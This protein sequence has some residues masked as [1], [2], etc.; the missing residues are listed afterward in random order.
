MKKK[1][2]LFT[3]QSNIGGY[4]CQESKKGNYNIDRWMEC[5]QKYWKARC[6]LCRVLIAYLIH[7]L[8]CIFI[9]KFGKFSIN[10]IFFSYFF[11]SNNK[12]YLTKYEQILL[13]WI[14]MLCYRLSLGLGQSQWKLCWPNQWCTHEH[15]WG[16]VVLKI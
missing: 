11:I 15:N 5:V 1:I 9:H 6:V 13:F 4:Y 14:D 3:W 16:Q 12:I 2:F 10:N 8:I 7:Y